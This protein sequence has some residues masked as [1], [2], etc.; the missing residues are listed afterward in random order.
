MKTKRTEKSILNV[1]SNFFIYIF[2]ALMLFVVRTIFIK[3]LGKEMLGLDG[4][5]TNILQVLSITELGISNAINFS[6]YKPLADKDYKKVSVLMSFYRRVYQVIGIIIVVMGLLIML[7]LNKI[8]TTVPSGVNIYLIYLIYLFDTVNLYFISYK[9]T[10]IVADQNNYQLLKYN[11]FFY[12]LMYILQIASLVIYRSFVLYLV[13]KIVVLLVQ[14][15]CINRFIT[16]KY[17]KIN[18]SID[19]K[20]SDKDLK[21]IKTNV[22]GLIFHKIGNYVIN[23]TDN[24]V[25][26]AFL[27]LTLVGIYANYLSLFGML[28]T[29]L[30]SSYRAITASFGNLIAMEDK[31]MQEEVFEK[32]NFAGHILYSF[33]S[34]AFLVLIN[35]FITLWLGKD[36]L[37]AT[38]VVIVICMNFYIDGMRQCLDSIKDASGVYDQDKYIPLIQSIVN[39]AVSIVLVQYIGIL[40]VVIG[41]LVSHLLLP[42][43]HRPYIV[44]KHVFKSS[45]KNYYIN[46]L[47][48]IFVISVTSFIIISIFGL[49]KM[50]LTLVSFVLYCI[51]YSLLYLIVISIIY[52]R[53][54]NYQFY[55]KLIYDRFR[56]KI[57]GV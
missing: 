16:K 9:E 37:L 54:K 5:Y 21:V 13:T 41:T 19:E 43:W 52:S 24:I 26:S 15:I 34:I 39:I 8:I 29:V 10:L 4:L 40:G 22:K 38:L 50:K 55:I 53:N 42:I 47:K 25:I 30:S 6:L 28:N 27:N 11:F 35:K 51:L 49:I 12:L 31:K 17:N 1:E 57:K 18:F 56:S 2:R 7:F 46:Y 23:G 14:R 44:Y 48:N 45:P 3:V 33:V 36:Y 20:I 32:I